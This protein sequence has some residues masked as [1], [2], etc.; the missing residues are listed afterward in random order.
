M[1]T[2][3]RVEPLTPIELPPG[4]GQTRGS[5]HEVWLSEEGSRVVKATHPGEFG[6]KFG[7]EP[8]ATLA[9]YLERVRLTVL[10]YGMDWRVLGAN[11]SGRTLRVVTSQPVLAG[12]PPAFDDLRDF[13]RADGFAL[14]RTRFGDAWFRET[15]GILVS[16]AEPKNAVETANGI[17]PFDF[18]IVRATPELLRAAGIR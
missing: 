3:F 9:E 16:D 11:G 15:D 7:P 1:E 17:I 13:M 6:R 8:F 10:E 2:H 5:E 18:L 4:L 14:H 12:R